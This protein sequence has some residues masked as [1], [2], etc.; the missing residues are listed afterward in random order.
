MA[1]AR[2]PIEDADAIEVRRFMAHHENVT[3][4]LHQVRSAWLIMRDLTLLR[5][6]TARVAPKNEN[7]F[8]LIGLSP[9]RPAPAPA[10]PA[11]AR[12]RVSPTP[13]AMDSGEYNDLIWRT[14]FSMLKR[15]FRRVGRNRR[16]NTHR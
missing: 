8:C 7:W 16:S 12:L 4:L 11:F 5:R 9:P 14:S 13:M 3:A 15:V 10:L 2:M 1:H 6:K